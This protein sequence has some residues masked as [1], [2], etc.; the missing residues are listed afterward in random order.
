MRQRVINVE[1]K[2]RE[3][4]LET[5]KMSDEKELMSVIGS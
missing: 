3:M 4:M 5:R 1:S 2:D